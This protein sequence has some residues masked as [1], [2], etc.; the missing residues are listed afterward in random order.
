MCGRIRNTTIVENGNF[1]KIRKKEKKWEQARHQK[2]WTR[3]PCQILLTAGVKGAAERG[4]YQGVVQSV[5]TGLDRCERK[6][7][8]ER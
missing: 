8:R 5:P 6:G 4:R 1:R 7:E 2:E 3:F